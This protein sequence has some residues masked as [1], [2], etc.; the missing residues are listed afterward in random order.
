MSIRRVVFNEKRLWRARRVTCVGCVL[1]RNAKAL[2]KVD[3]VPEDEKVKISVELQRT[4]VDGF[5]PYYAELPHRAEFLKLIEGYAI[6]IA[7]FNVRGANP[8]TPD[9]LAN[10]VQQI[11]NQQAT[12]GFTMRGQDELLV[13]VVFADRYTSSVTI[14]ADVFLSY[15]RCL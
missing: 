10:A 13:E 3:P 7:S 9:L 12:I 15:F 8:Y 4:D 6:E 1:M 11:L 14:P 5:S 2:F